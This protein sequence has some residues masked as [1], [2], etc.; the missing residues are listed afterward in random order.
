MVDFKKLLRILHVCE[1]CKNYE[2]NI[3]RQYSLKSCRFCVQD[4]TTEMIKE[5]EET[6]FFDS[7]FNLHFKY[8]EWKDNATEQKFMNK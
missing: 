7:Q 3:A 8:F 5:L 2:P 1:L 6:D 4:N